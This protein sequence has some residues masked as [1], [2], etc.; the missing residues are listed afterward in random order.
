MITKA[1][2]FLNKKR[3]FCDKKNLARSRKYYTLCCKNV[4]KC[5]E[6]KW[7]GTCIKVAANGGFT[8]LYRV[9]QQNLDHLKANL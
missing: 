5:S 6:P 9:Y 1:Y 8:V 3:M 7:S 2:I 4:K